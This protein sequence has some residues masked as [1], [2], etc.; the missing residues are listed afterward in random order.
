MQI[1]SVHLSLE[2]GQE[3]LL[4]QEIRGHRRKNRIGG[5]RKLFF[6]FHAEFAWF[7]GFPC[8]DTQQMLRKQS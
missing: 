3:M 2:T 1:N 6:F 5:E 7:V 8:R 4:T